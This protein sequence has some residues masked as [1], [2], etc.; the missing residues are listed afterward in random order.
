MKALRP[1]LL[2]PLALAAACSTYNPLRWVGIIDAPPNPPTPLAAIKATANPVAVWTAS[3]GKAAGFMFQ[4][5]EDAGHVY[6]AAADG[7]VTVVDAA[8]GRV[9]SRIETK[10]HLSGGLAAGDGKIFAGTVDGEVIALEPSG[11]LDWATPV[12][13]EVIAPA[14]VS[15][16]VAV[17]RTTDGRLLG[18]ATADG[19]RK[20]VFQRPSPSLLL[21]SPAGVITVDGDVVAGY[22]NGKLLALD[23]DDGKLTWEVT[24][25]LPTGA[26]ELERIADV[27]G[28]PAIDG[29]DVCA[30]AFQGKVAC[31]E[32]QT[33]NMIWSRELSTAHNLVTDAKNLYLVDGTG[34]VQA[35]DKKTGSSVW[36]NDKL[37]Y[38][39]LTSPLVV[40]GN[41]VVG[42]GF[43]Y[44]HVLSADDGALIGRLPTD[45]TAVLSLVPATTGFIAQTAGGSLISVRFP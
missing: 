45:G 32:I 33:R 17:V 20:W 10:K 34:A 35:L 12:L 4:P 11:K 8:N 29:A 19:K 3:V 44:L 41:I 16:G 18:L 40:N 25:S 2:A 37:L 22:S 31:F 36:K 9:A 26:T 14:S 13:G 42:D 28:L 21:R 38:R 1:M 24:V 5:A 7:T 30:A 15:R 27:A 23:I 6:A 43:G 39:R